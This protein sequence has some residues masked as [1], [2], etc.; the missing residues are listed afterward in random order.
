M[1]GKSEV[2]LV[3]VNII[4]VYKARSLLTAYSWQRL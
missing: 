4:Y 2:I 1:T 3:E